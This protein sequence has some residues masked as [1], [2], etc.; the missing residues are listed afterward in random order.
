M[1]TVRLTQNLV[2]ETPWEVPDG[3]GGFEAG[4]QVLGT[5]W[6]ELSPRS[7]REVQ[8]EAGPVARGRYRITVRGA[9]V[10]AS[11]RPVPGQRFRLGERVFDILTVSE[12]DV[13]G[14]YLACEAQEEVAS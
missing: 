1:K 11:S 5:L 13:S 8:G 10:G 3:T 4:W 12:R 7:G 9:P 2:L 6:A 14:R